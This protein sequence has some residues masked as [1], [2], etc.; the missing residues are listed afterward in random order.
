MQSA[1]SWITS[2]ALSCK[3]SHQLGCDLFAGWDHNLN[4]GVCSY[5][6]SFVWWPSHYV[7]VVWRHVLAGQ[8]FLSFG[9]RESLPRP[10]G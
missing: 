8:Q 1:A 10:G 2:F 7:Q 3:K 9:R 6:T 4:Y 5:G